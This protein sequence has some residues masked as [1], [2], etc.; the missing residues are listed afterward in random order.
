MV[1]EVVIF[2]GQEGAHKVKWNFVNTDWITSFF[3]KLRDQLTVGGKDL[4]WCL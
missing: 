4:K 3:T 1:S 2:G